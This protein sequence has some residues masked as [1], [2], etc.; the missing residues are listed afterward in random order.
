MVIRSSKHF[1]LRSTSSLQ[2]SR[3][4]FAR[5]AGRVDCRLPPPPPCPQLFLV[6]LIVG[7]GSAR[8][9]VLGWARKAEAML[10]HH[11]A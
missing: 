10:M 8:A 7:V 4:R 2:L 9:D 11:I 5:T 3:L 1:Q 6:I